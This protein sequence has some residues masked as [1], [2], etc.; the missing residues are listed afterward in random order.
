[1]LPGGGGCNKARN[2][3]ACVCAYAHGGIAG[4][5]TAH[6]YFP[7]FVMEQ[8]P[9]Q[10]RIGG[11]CSAPPIFFS[12]KTEQA[13]LFRLFLE[14]LGVVCTAPA[15]ILYIQYKVVIHMHHFMEQRGGDGFQ[16]AVKCAACNVYLPAIGVFA[17]PS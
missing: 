14:Y 5:Y 16:G 17:L 3:V 2:T 4:I 8:Q 12:T 9:F 1:M 13:V 10:K 7:E 15:A 11:G 6:F